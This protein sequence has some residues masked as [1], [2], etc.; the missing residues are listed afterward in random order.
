MQNITHDAQVSWPPYPA[1][2]NQIHFHS[3]WV[4]VNLLSNKILDSVS[5][6]SQ[7]LIYE[8]GIHVSI[9]HSNLKVFKT[10]LKL[11]WLFLVTRVKTQPRFVPGLPLIC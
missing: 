3:P 5:R 1:K 7:S 9:P 10:S 11:L 2:K 4:S 8:V 6:Q